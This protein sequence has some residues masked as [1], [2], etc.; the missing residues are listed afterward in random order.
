LAGF[1]LFEEKVGRMGIFDFLKKQSKQ[2]VE[3]TNQMVDV[4]SAQ[5][6]TNTEAST[7]DSSNDSSVDFD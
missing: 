7:D 6:S 2:N 3:Q 4:E 5:E 1:F